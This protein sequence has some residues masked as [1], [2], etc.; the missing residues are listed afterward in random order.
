MMPRVPEGFTEQVPGSL[1]RRIITL[2]IYDEDRE[3]PYIATERDRDGLPIEVQR[4]P[5]ERR[6]EARPIVL[7]DAE[8]CSDTCPQRR[9]SN[10]WESHICVL[11]GHAQKLHGMLRTWTC[12]TKEE[13]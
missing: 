13:S 9:W 6:T 1:V 3:H 8:H 12:R 10:I 2:D 11:T 7:R 4:Y 5:V